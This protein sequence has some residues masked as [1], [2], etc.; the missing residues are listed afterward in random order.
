MSLSRVG[1]V[2]LGT[3]F[4]G[5][6][7]IW[8][9]VN[10]ADGSTLLYSRWKITTDPNSGWSDWALFPTNPYMGQIL[11]APMFLTG[12]SQLFA[13]LGD[14]STLSWT[15]K[16]AAD[17]NA[18]W[19]P[20]SSFSPNFPPPP[21]A[22]Y[23]P[24][25]MARFAGAVLGGQLSGFF[26]NTPVQLWIIDYAGALW[27]IRS[28]PG[29][30]IIDNAPSTFYGE[31]QDWTLFQPFPPEGLRSVFPL[32]CGG[33]GTINAPNSFPLWVVGQSGTLYVTNATLLYFG[34]GGNLSGGPNWSPWSKFTQ[35]PEAPV[36]SLVAGQLTDG[37]IQIFASDTNGAIFSI[38]QDTNGN[39]PSF[40][41]GFAQPG[42][43]PIFV[44][45]E[46]IALWFHQ[47]KEDLTLAIAPLPDGRLQLF[48]IDDS[49][50]I[51]SAWKTSIDPN[52]GW[53]D[54]SP[55]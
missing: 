24:P 21:N 30:V 22:E 32:Y 14:G 3:L 52:S 25:T 35:L 51:W 7:Q 18:G 38:W 49:A 9:Q 11:T 46:N 1:S 39:W 53:T 5:R 45:Q 42:G 41:Q 31:G 23:Q 8:A 15:L 27:T 54:W 20:W 48:A 37:R 2:V 19:L 13:A 33:A 17:S 29:P 34:A 10:Q 12:Q 16:V 26:A 43:K 36:D 50:N 28:V 6:L 55:F 40:W 47:L 4:D 44:S